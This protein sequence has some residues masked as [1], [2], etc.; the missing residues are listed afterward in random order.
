MV[1]EGKVH[2][3]FPDYYWSIGRYKAYQLLLY[4]AA[5]EVESP[6]VYV[7]SF[8]RLKADFRSE[9]RRVADFLGFGVSDERIAEIQDETSI[10]KMRKARGE[11]GKDESQRFIRK[12]AV[13]DWRNHFD[14]EMLA[15]LDRIRERGLGPAERTKYHLV[16]TA[17]QAVKQFLSY[18]SRALFRLL[19]KV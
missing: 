16:F 7:S 14:E 9:V 15:D 18:R 5:W 6:R 13:G 11:E 17:R 10:E 4:R 1:R 8:E 3:E 19:R 2:A 12:G